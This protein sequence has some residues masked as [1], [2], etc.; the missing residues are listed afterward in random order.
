M[1]TIKN[2]V[3]L[4]A[5]FLLI[6]ACNPVNDNPKSLE[7]AGHSK[8]VS[9]VPNPDE[10]ISNQLKIITLG[11]AG[12]PPADFG[13]AQPATIIQVEGRNYLIDVGEGAAHQLRQ[14]PIS[15]YSL[16]AVFISHLHWDHTL[17]M[18]YLLAT[19]WM[20]GRRKS[21]PI[22]GPPGTNVFMSNLLKTIGV[23][24]AIF[25]AQAQNRPL[26]LDLFPFDEVDTCA[27]TTVFQDDRVKVTSVCSSHFDQVRASDHSYG[28]DRA[29]AY[30]FDTAHGSITVTGDTGPS[31]AVEKL[32]AG[33]DVLVSEIVDVKTIGEALTK[34]SPNADLS[35]LKAHMEHQHLTA[36]AVGEMATAAG[37]KTVVLT[38][39]VMG[40]DFD[41]MDFKAQVR[42]YFDGE[43]IVGNDL[44]EIGL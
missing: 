15:P 40:D 26:I 17:G 36:K 24:E 3:T 6:T 27:P 37:V 29:L 20:M 25:R 10:P 11:T 2:Y 38:H 14:V 8:P 30:R 1:M 32:A 5:S 28:P 19:S 44:M 43:I 41:P 4:A 39:F 23:G 18:D 35:K 9:Q 33:S 42:A 21:L 12:G 16:D 22:F 13:R 31:E 34:N 7:T